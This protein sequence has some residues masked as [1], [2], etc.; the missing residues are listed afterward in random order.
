MRLLLQGSQSVPVTRTLRDGRFIRLTPLDPLTAS[1]SY[2]VQVTG[3]LDAQG[4][5]V[6]PAFNFAFSTGT[7]SDATAPT[8]TAVAPPGGSTDVGTNA[9]IRVRFSEPIN[10]LTVNGTTIAVTAPGFLAV[11]TDITFNTGDTEVTVTPVQPFPSNATLTIDVAGVEDRAGLT[12][13]PLQS[14]FQTG[15]DVDTETPSI[16]Q[17]NPFSGQTNVPVNTV[18]TVE[19]SELLDPASIRA[20]TVRLVDA[21]TNLAVPASITLDATGRTLQVAPFR[22]WSP[23]AGTTSTSTTRRPRATS[24][25]TTPPRSSWRSRRRTPPTSSPRSCS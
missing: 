14:S 8:V 18:M 11:P 17:S 25:A 21:T 12:V 22:R 13:T 23:P 3:V 4:Q 16:V 19:F 6:S 5:P 7:A 24:R 15:P 10:P 9:L 1:Q 20:D 2:Y